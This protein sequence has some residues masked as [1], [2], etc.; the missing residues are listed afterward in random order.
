MNTKAQLGL[1]IL[2]V[3]FGAL[4]MMQKAF[5]SDKAFITTSLITAF[6]GL[7]L[8]IFNLVNDFVLTICI[9]SIIF[10][11]WYMIKSGRGEI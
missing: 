11:L 2:L 9:L 7:L 10:S 1:G 3:V 4:F 6:L 5:G 8:R